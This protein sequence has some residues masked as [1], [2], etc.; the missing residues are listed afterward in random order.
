M[1]LRLDRLEDAEAALVK[2]ISLD[3]ELKAAHSDLGTVHYRRGEYNKAA[4]E[5]KEA[6]KANPDDVVARYNLA[7]AFR[8]LNKP[9]EA[10]EQYEKTLA[11]D[12]TYVDCYFNMGLAY[13]DMGKGEDAVA[14]FERFIEAA[15][16]DPEQKEWVDRAKE[17]IAD[18]RAAGKGK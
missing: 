18:I 8:N 5:F 11:K 16:N 1:A 2:A 7:N 17:Y 4:L 10:V 13:E 14:A 9:A 15:K 12:P 3:P 6:L